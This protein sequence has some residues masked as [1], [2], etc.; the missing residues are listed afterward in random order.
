MTVHRLLVGSLVTNCYLLIFSDRVAVIDPGD[1]PDRIRAACN[2][3]P[4]T[5]VLLTHAHFDHTSALG[6]LC[7]SYKPRVWLHKGD[8]AHLNEDSLRA[9]LSFPHA[10]WRYDLYATDRFA[11][12]CE[13]PLGD[14]DEKI[15]LRAIH[16]PGHT[17]GSVCYLWDEGKTLF[18]GDTLFKGSM[19]RC[20]FPLGDEKTLFASLRRLGTL[21]DETA[22]LPGHGFYTTIGAERW[23]RGNG[24]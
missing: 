23:I 11:D 14:Q 4:I 17:P 19:G 2:G 12:G 1:A 21:P 24:I 5:D 15:T 20:D 18:S 13:I 8:I 3:L 10:D 7:D 9:P 22:V 6:A 16:T